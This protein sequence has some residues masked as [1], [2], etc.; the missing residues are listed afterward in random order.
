MLLVLFSVSAA[1]GAACNAV[2]V[3]AAVLGT[4]DVA[5]TS[6]AAYAAGVA[7]PCADGAAVAACATV[8]TDSFFS[9]LFRHDTAGDGSPNC[10]VGWCWL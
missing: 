1:A 8:G 3:C 5:D 10:T 6:G 7:A 9:A 4:A 2:A